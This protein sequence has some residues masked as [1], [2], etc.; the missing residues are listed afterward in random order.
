MVLLEYYKIPIRDKRGIDRFQLVKT[1]LKQ[2]GDETQLDKAYDYV[3]KLS[4]NRN[5]DWK[6]LWPDFLK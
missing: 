3:E 2:D 5:F 1:H 4:A 6:K